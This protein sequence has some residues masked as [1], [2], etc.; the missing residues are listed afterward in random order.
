MSRRGGDASEVYPRSTKRTTDE[1]VAHHSILPEAIDVEPLPCAVPPDN[2]APEGRPVCGEPRGDDVRRHL[3][4]EVAVGPDDREEPCVRDDEGVRRGPRDLPETPVFPR[5]IALP[6]L[7]PQV[8]PL[9]IEHAYLMAADHSH[10][11]V[12][13][14]ESVRHLVQQVRL[15]A[16]DPTDLQRGRI[17]DPPLREIGVPDAPEIDDLDAGGVA[18]DGCPLGALGGRS[19]I[20]CTEREKKQEEA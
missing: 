5:P 11:A 9:R 20:A 1:H 18:D 10:P 2:L 3:P 6:S 13:H 19:R 16:L 15:R 14:H 17:G 4:H 8:P 12:R 7:G